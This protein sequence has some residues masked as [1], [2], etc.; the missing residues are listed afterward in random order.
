MTYKRVA[1]IGAIL[2]AVLFLELLID[3][4]LLIGPWGV[5]H[6]PEAGFIGRRLGA[7]FLG[8][9]VILWLSRS[10]PASAARRAIA[11]GIAT[12]LV[13]VAGFGLYELTRGFASAGILAAVAVE[14][15]L[16]SAL[17]VTGRAAT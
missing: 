13:V 4:S 12:A 6:T 14:L 2:F 15:G 16:A 10:L 17:F 3:V 11:L 9:A 5:E 7:G 8:F 1:M